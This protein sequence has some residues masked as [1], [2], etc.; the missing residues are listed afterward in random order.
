[1]SDEVIDLTLD[2]SSASPSPAAKRA[3]RAEQP[4]EGAGPSG[5]RPGKRKEPEK[6]SV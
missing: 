4:S 6:V 2:S 3:K 1:M 5:S